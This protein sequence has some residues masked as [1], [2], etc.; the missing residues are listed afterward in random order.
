MLKTTYQVAWCALSDI[1]LVRDCNEDRWAAYPDIGLFLLADGMGGHLAGEIAAEE[2]VRHLGEGI[3]QFHQERDDPL[4]QL[5]DDFYQAYA[6]TNSYIFEKGHEDPTLQ[7]M[8]T[9]LASIYFVQNEAIVANVGDS[10]IYRYRSQR[11]VQLTEDHS[12]VNELLA[13]GAIKEEEAL[14]FPYKHILTRAIGTHP[15]VIP[16]IQLIDVR[17]KDLYLLCTDGLNNFVSD[18]ELAKELKQQIE[19]KQQAFNL[20]DLAKKNGGGDN[21]TILLIQ[22]M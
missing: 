17:P 19:L 1:G 13:I 12:L 8:G 5:I 16:S 11:L 3:K 20:V 9:T 18:E 14:T 15:T 4:E 10:R 2:A 6:E 7:G 22:V 21:I